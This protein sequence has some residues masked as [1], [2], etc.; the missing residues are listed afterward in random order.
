M[1]EFWILCAVASV[2]GV[3]CFAFGFILS[4][5]LRIADDK[6]RQKF[7]SSEQQHNAASP[8][9]TVE[10]PVVTLPAPPQYERA[11]LSQPEPENEQRV[12][13]SPVGAPAPLEGWNAGA[14]AMRAAT[15]APAGAKVFLFGD[16]ATNSVTPTLPLPSARVARPY[17]WPSGQQPVS[18]FTGGTDILPHRV[19]KGRRSRARR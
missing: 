1:P 10:P 16:P 5:V 12:F 6:A 13:T 9:T 2:W 17:H 3:V 18:R 15:T 8:A 7:I 19:E 11:V 14:S 4:V